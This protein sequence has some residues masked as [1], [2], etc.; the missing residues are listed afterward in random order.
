MKYF[1][2]ILFTFILSGCAQKT[3]IMDK[4]QKSLLN[5]KT[6]T[7]IEKSR[8]NR[9]D[10]STPG[11]A[12][13]AAM[14][15]IFGAILLSV[16]DES[17]SKLKTPSNYISKEIAPFI[18]NKYHMIF[19]KEK[20]KE[21]EETALSIMTSKRN[22]PELDQFK[23]SYSSD[24]LLDVNTYN[25]IIT[26]RLWSGSASYLIVMRN[27]LRLIER[28]SQKIISST[29]CEYFP[30]SKE[31]LLTHKE[32]FANNGEMI[33]EESQKAINLCIEKIKTEL[34]Q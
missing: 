25:W 26:H 32:L 24:Y 14:G 9:P 27:N 20:R 13:G 33:K 18:A 1:T 22:I 6:L 21:K 10:I 29:S 30:K 15:G 5:N 17:I 4:K 7:F 19:K 31:E 8:P 2:A 16:N 34:F 3:L 12:I 11:K 23:E 28:E